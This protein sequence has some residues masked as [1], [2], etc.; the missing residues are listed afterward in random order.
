MTP[1]EIVEAIRKSPNFW[2]ERPLPSEGL[3]ADVPF[4]DDFRALVDAG[5]GA[6]SAGL[7][8]IKVVPLA[9]VLEEIRGYY[10]PLADLGF[11]VLTTDHGGNAVAWDAREGRVVAI[12]HGPFGSLEEGE[13]GWLTE[14]G[15]PFDPRDDP[16]AMWE[17]APTFC[18]L[19][20]RQLGG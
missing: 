10:R 9:A 2:G 18:E 12:D 1:H 7:D 13:G 4:P 19:L 15:E 6:L 17:L 14:D 3:P 16:D 11:V 8:D 20:E 5:Y